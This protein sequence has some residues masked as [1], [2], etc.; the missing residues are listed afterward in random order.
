[1]PLTE[2]EEKS[3]DS[4]AQEVQKEELLNAQEEAQAVQCVDEEEIEENNRLESRFK[5][6]V[7]DAIQ[8]LKK[9]QRLEPYDPDPTGDP[10]FDFYR[11]YLLQVLETQFEEC[12]KFLRGD[13]KELSDNDRFD[14]LARYFLPFYCAAVE[15]VEAKQEA[16]LKDLLARHQILFPKKAAA[17]ANSAASAAE[18]P[19]APKF[20]LSSHKWP[21]KEVA[22]AMAQ[23]QEE[24]R[25]PR[26]QSP[27]P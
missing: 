8:S 27:C 5:R 11:R 18:T 9:S 6:L 20:G 14:A 1:M 26:S 22:A 2:T 13:Q 10:L 15:K 21:A 3:L 4:K 25:S 7:G 23:M 24:Q 19:H 17:G 16:L 12:A